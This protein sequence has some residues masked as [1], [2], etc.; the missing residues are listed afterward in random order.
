VGL[1]IGHVSPEAA[2]GGPIALIA[3]GDTIVVDVNHETLDCVELD[4]A[5]ILAAR[6]ARWQAEADRNGGIHPLVRPVSTRLLRRMRACALPPLQGAGLSE[7][8][9]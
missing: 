8:G 4:D 2:L 9:L 1:V 7:A 3:D 5:T 6:R